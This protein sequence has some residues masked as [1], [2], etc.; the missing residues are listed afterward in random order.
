MYWIDGKPTFGYSWWSMLINT[1]ENLNEKLWWFSETFREAIE[2]P[3]VEETCTYFCTDEVISTICSA[4]QEFLQVTR[5]FCALNCL[6][7]PGKN[8]CHYRDLRFLLPLPVSLTEATGTVIRKNQHS[9][10]NLNLSLVHFWSK[11]A[12]GVVILENNLFSCFV[13]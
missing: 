13:V 9:S 11:L 6:P 10:T 8:S 1:T 7:F 5:S 2:W 12:C 3:F 4:L